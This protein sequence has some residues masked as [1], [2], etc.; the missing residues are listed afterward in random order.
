MVGFIERHRQYKMIDNLMKSIVPSK[1]YIRQEQWTLMCCRTALKETH[2]YK[3]VNK[4]ILVL[5]YITYFYTVPFYVHHVKP[6]K[7]TSSYTR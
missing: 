2:Q 5:R 3:I 7:G 1:L 4:V 6:V